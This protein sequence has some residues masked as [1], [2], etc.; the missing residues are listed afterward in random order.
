MMGTYH[1]SSG[2]GYDQSYSSARTE[3]DDRDN[4]PG[5]NF[6]GSRSALSSDYIDHIQQTVPPAIT[7]TETTTGSRR[8]HG[9]SLNTHGD[10]HL[11]RYTGSLFEAP[12]STR[13]GRR[14]KLSKDRRAHANEV[15]KRGACDVCRRRKHKVRL[16]L[17]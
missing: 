14:G 3:I 7:Q 6:P 5:L 10:A 2:Y 16:G 9:R 12:S 11:V 8:G 4:R 13:P 17:I 1:P 15:R